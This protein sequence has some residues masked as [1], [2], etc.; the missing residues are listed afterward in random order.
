[1]LY[2]KESTEVLSIETVGKIWEMLNF[3]TCSVTVISS[4][5]VDNWKGEGKHC[6]VTCQATTEERVRYRSNHTR[7]WWQRGW[8]VSLMPQPL[9]PG[10]ETWYLLYRRLEGLGAGLDGSGKSRKH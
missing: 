9:Y 7:L 5:R 3:S 4:T 1:M 2:K 10:K 8:V 6:P